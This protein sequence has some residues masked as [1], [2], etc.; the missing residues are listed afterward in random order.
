MNV[1]GPGRNRFNA[2]VLIPELRAT[3]RR[4]DVKIYH[5]Q[6][7]CFCSASG[8]PPTGRARRSSVMAGGG[9]ERILGHRLILSTSCLVE[10]QGARLGTGRLRTGAN[11]P[12]PM[13]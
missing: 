1:D 4:F 13:K 12:G 10:A 7:N 3:H 5:E 9:I 11:G 6:A 2:D 8:A